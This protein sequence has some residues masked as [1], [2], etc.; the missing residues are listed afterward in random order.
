[1]WLKMAKMCSSAAL[2]VKGHSQPREASIKVCSLL[3]TSGETVPLLAGW[4]VCVSLVSCLPFVNTLRLLRTHLDKPG[5]SSPRKILNS[6][7]L[8]SSF[9]T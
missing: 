3:G 2:E 4:R 8:A 1:M 9:T 5:Q 6:T 7:T